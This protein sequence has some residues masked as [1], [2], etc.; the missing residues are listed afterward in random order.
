MEHKSSETTKDE[1]KKIRFSLNNPKIERVFLAGDSNG[2][3][4]VIPEIFG[5]NEHIRLCH[6]RLTRY[7]L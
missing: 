5:M 6:G 7:H 1:T 3:I 4:L 2:C